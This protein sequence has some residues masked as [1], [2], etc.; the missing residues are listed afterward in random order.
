MQSAWLRKVESALTFE[1]YACMQFDRSSSTVNALRRLTKSLSMD[2][3]DDDFYG[4]ASQAPVD[5]S[6]VKPAVKNE[7]AEEAYDSGEEDSD[8]V[9]K[10]CS[11]LIELVY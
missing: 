1:A 7:Q 5:A 4:A 6:D 2:D 9:W 3:D 11:F 10:S 8:D